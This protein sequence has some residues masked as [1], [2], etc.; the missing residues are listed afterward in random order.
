[1]S[2]ATNH[3]RKRG[4]IFFGVWIEPILRDFVQDVARDQRLSV[5]EYLEKVLGEEMKRHDARLR[6][7]LARL[8]AVRK[9]LS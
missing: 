2:T 3:P 8:R 4:K 9:R 6:V 1:M 5:A 7:Q